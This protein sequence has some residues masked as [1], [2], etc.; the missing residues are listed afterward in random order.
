M[1]HEA[2]D[3]E[4]VAGLAVDVRRGFPFAREFARDSVILAVGGGSAIDCAKAI[5]VAAGPFG[6]FTPE[7]RREA[8]QL[9][10]IS[11]F[12]FSRDNA[13]RTQGGEGVR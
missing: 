5:A 3:Q 4:Q 2:H 10:V 13:L 7:M 12:I 9:A 11:R 8:D 6:G 1:R